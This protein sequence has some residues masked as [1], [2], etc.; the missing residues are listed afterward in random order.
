MVVN[1]GGDLQVHET[2][3][4]RNEALDNV[5]STI[6]GIVTITDSSFQDNQHTAI[7][8][9]VFVDSDST[10]MRNDN[11][12][13]L[14]N[15][16]AGGVDPKDDHCGGIFVAASSSCEA[17]SDDCEGSCDKFR[18]KEPPIAPPCISVWD[19]LV[20]SIRT[21]NAADRGASIIICPST[22]FV[23][24]TGEDEDEATQPVMITTSG[25]K[26]MCGQDGLRDN[27]CTI[28]GGYDHFVLG[29][30]EMTVEFSGLTMKAS[31]GLAS[32]IAA[33]DSVGG[34]LHRLSLG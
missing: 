4:L 32:V 17:G 6:D 5:V 12:F 34:H 14:D 29:G 24:S 2:V 19:D 15:E 28:R 3:F 8:G 30:T 10:L 16:D 27:E 25:I 1:D 31:T 22:E 23:L 33:A 11:N 13:G 20:N 21:A 26:M 9:V 18:A 7:T